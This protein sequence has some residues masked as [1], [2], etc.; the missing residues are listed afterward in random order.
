MG[1]LQGSQTGS[2]PI[3]VSWWQG[4]VSFGEQP[5]VSKVPDGFLRMP[6]HVQSY[7]RNN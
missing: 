5:T 1:R 7:P 2:V 4:K 3:P 6:G